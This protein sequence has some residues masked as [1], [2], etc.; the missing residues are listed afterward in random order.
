[1]PPINS[2]K[3]WF[4]KHVRFA[5]WSGVEVVTDQLNNAEIRFSTARF[6]YT[7]WAD[8]NGNEHYLGCICVELVGQRG[9]DL[10][11][12]PFLKLFSMKSILLQGFY[13][14]L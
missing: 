11:D 6:T 2:L 1:M 10:L 13:D 9:C 14:V 5:N 4:E 3:N 7:I 12:G 8:T